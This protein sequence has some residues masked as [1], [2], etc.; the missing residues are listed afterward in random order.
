MVGK[1]A[2]DDQ[3]RETHVRFRKNTDYEAYINAID[4]DYEWEDAIFNVYI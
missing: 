2:V 3:I 1:V 4:Q